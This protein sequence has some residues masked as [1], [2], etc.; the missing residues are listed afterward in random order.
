[1]V[2]AFAATLLGAAFLTAIF[3]TAAD[4]AF[5]A[6]Q[7]L[8][9]AA[10]IAALPAGESLR[11]DL[12]VTGSDTIFF[13]AHLFFNAA[14][15]FALPAALIFRRR[16]VCGFDA[17]SGWVRFPSSIWRTSAICSSMAR[18]WIQSPQSLRAVSR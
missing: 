13:A 15:I 17:L 4:A 5:F 18:F 11:F 3:S 16:G 2:G 7:R 12:V 6:A 14:T 8:F 10:T 1:V 9:N